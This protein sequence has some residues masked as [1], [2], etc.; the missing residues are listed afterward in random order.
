VARA[1]NKR[2]RH[3]AGLKVNPITPVGRGGKNRRQQAQLTSGLFVVDGKNQ[4]A[5]RTINTAA[6]TAACARRDIL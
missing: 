6:K 4:S 2:A 3:E 1:G 5:R